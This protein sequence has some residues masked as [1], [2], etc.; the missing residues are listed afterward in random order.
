VTTC[1]RAS[2]MI[3]GSIF[4]ILSGCILFA[5]IVT[6]RERH[7][8]LARQSR[9]R[10][11][12]HVPKQKSLDSAPT[13]PPAAMLA[14]AANHCQGDRSCPFPPLFKGRCRQHARDALANGSQ[15]GTAHA[16]LRA[17]GLVEPAETQTRPEP[18]YRRRCKGARKP[19]SVRD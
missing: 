4:V 8:R 1:C 10:W 15:V 5:M 19:A 17:F 6:E 18:A 3:S 7:E 14:A 12:L 16:L 13:V 11:A 9:K 2:G